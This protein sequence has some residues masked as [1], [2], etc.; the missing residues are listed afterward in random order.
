M[1]LADA[2]YARGVERSGSAPRCVARSLISRPSTCRTTRA[3]APEPVWAE[4][5][6]QQTPVVL[7]FLGSTLDIGVLR[8]LRR[9][10]ASPCDR[11]TPSFTQD[12]LLVGQRLGRSAKSLCAESHHTEIISFP[13]LDASS[14]RNPPP[15]SEHER[16]RPMRGKRV[17][18]LARLPRGAAFRV[19]SMSPAGRG[20]H[21]GRP[22]SATRGK[23]QVKPG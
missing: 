14:R 16:G 9:R 17:R 8:L 3:K 21:E 6:K 12:R 4:N 11:Q 23:A 20:A 15:R 2:L 7:G 1:S 5:Q 22:L 19:R 10:A 18:S 13:I